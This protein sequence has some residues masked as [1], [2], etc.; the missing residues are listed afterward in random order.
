MSS[1]RPSVNL[2]N[3]PLIQHKLGVMRERTT[4][5]KDFRALLREISIFLTYESLRTIPLDTRAIQTPLAPTVTAHIEEQKIVVIS[6]LRA[7]NGILEGVLD[8]I[9]G[10]RAGHIGLYRDPAT[11]HPVEYY[12]KVPD[13]L[14]GSH[15]L[16]VDPMLA[17]GHS[18][19]AAATKIKMLKPASLR[20]ICLLAAPEGIETFA[21][22]H[23]DVSIVTAAID[24]RLNDHG[25]IVPG[26]G[27]A[28]DRIYGTK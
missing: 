1:T 11:L 27:D 16:M 28:G 3:H 14:P 9:P 5:P 4:S 20:F 25:Y 13:S 6:I 23:P 10:A 19:V 7:G 15:A 17:T 21:A 2:V 22:A 24:E 12:F 26:L 18:A 8:T